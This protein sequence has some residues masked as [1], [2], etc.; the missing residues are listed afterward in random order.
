MPAINASPTYTRTDQRGRYLPK[1]GYQ[2][3]LPTPS[4]SKRKKSPKKKN[5]TTMALEY[6]YRIEI[7]LFH[8]PRKPKSC[9]SASVSLATRCVRA[10]P[11]SRW[12]S[13]RCGLFPA[14]RPGLPPPPPESPRKLRRISSAPI[15]SRAGSSPSRAPTRPDLRRERA[16][17]KPRDEE[18]VE[19]IEEENKGG[20]RRRRRR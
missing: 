17:G 5:L 6:T 15:R 8:I 11:T 2:S 19:K 10:R 3:P 12:N 13:C 4:P 18:R 16:A 1:Q 7:N 20:Y 14:R 9:V